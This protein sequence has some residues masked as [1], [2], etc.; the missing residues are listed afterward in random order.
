MY[1]RLFILGCSLALSFAHGAWA[2]NE[3]SLSELPQVRYP[4]EYRVVSGALEAADVRRLREAGIRHVIN[5]RPT[6]ENPQFDEAREVLEQGLVYHYIPIR[7]GQSLTSENARELDRLLEQIGNE[8]TLIHCSSGNRVGA[9]IAV[10]EAWI[11]GRS[12][13][14][15]IAEGKN[16]GLT[17]LESTVR[18]LLED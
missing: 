9:L 13:D 1:G 10:R 15:A 8:P 3:A 11:K 5:L 16:W 7:G 4:Q 2:L 14:A 17:K 12:A 6:E 18:D